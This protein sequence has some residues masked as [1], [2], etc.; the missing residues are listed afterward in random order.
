MTK[1]I[2][3]LLVSIF[4]IFW[5]WVS[6]ANPIAPT[7]YCNVIKNVEIDSYRVIIEQGKRNINLEES[8]LDNSWRESPSF[9]WKREVYELKAKECTKCSGWHWWFT[10]K[11]KVY[12]LDKSIDISDIAQE[13]IDDKAIFVWE[14]NSF[15][16]S[17]SYYDK[18]NTYKITKSWNGYNLE[19]SKTTN[20]RVKREIKNNLKIFPYA[21]FVTII[22]ETLLLFVISK[23]NW[24]EEKFSNKKIIL[25]WIIPT[26]ITLPL[27]WFALPL[28]MWI[29]IRYNIIWEILVISLEAIIIKYWLN[30]SRWNAIKA[31]IFCNIISL[32]LWSII[33]GLLDGL[34]Y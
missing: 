17:D 6:F 22:I 12:L 3:F 26:T 5:F 15:E 28:L 9:N 21:W 10:N 2:W 1:K 14:I 16:C 13:N 20:E 8:N 7:L 24:K 18:V 25:F 19:L 33:L 23:Y 29:W 30:I 11:S 31:S 32:M 34:L 27:F 4:V